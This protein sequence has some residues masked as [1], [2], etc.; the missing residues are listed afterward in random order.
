MSIYDPIGNKPNP[1][2]QLDHLSRRVTELED[3]LKAFRESIE[4]DLRKIKK[5]TEENKRLI[6]GDR[7]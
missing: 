1:R 2:S 3:S 7:Q 5:K 4:K 6:S